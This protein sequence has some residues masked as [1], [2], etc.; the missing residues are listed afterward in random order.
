[1]MIDDFAAPSGVDVPVRV[2]SSGGRSGEYRCEYVATEVGA[3]R[4]EMAVTGRTVEGSP[5]YVN[6]YAP[7]KVFIDPIPGGAVGKPVQFYG[8]TLFLS[9]KPFLK[10]KDPDFGEFTSAL[11]CVQP[12]LSTYF[13]MMTA[14]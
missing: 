11:Y 10:L 12:Q 3:Y 5:F 9:I 13:S 14:G 6:A 8:Q 7:N 4:L 2:M 1:M